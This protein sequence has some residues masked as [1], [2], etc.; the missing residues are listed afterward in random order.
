MC[1]SQ[2]HKLNKCTYGVR[3]LRTLH[4]QVAQGLTLLA[5]IGESIIGIGKYLQT[6]QVTHPQK[7]IS[8]DSHHPSQKHDSNSYTCTSVLTPA[9]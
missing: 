8:R 9:D 5:R 7:R 2:P 1:G 4:S 3:I 6:K